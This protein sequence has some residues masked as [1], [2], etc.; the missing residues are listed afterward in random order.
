MHPLLKIHIEQKQFHHAYLLCGDA[1]TCRERALEAAKAILFP[2]STSVFDENVNVHPDF[3][4]QKFELFGID[5]SRELKA[6]AAGRAVGGSRVFV[7]E[8]FSFNMESA[9]A[10]LKL[11]EEPVSGVHFFVIVPSAETVIPTLRS[12]MAVIQLGGS[13]SKSKLEVEPPS[14]GK[15]EEFLRNPPV[16]R[17]ALAKKIGEKEGAKKEITEIIN[18]MEVI[19]EKFVFDG[20]KWKAAAKAM[21]EIQRS[22][23]FLADRG[24]SAKMI[25]EHLALTLPRL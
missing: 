11:M 12:R 10:M 3:L 14:V 22:R 18:G 4:H 6:R 21:E 13:T 8:I 9:N 23:Q 7:L 20:G 5:D 15:A 19:F 16:K 1:E 25:L 2:S 24:S 17:L